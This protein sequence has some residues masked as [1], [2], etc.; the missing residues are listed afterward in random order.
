MSALEISSIWGSVPKVVEKGIGISYPIGKLNKRKGGYT[1]G[2]RITKG[3][4][5]QRVVFLSPSAFS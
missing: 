2:K 1:D 4:R 5:A 3:L